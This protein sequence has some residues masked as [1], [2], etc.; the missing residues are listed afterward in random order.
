MTE[1]ERACE[2]MLL[3]RAYLYTLLHKAF[4]GEPTSELLALLGGREAAEVLDLFAEDSEV[5]AKC[6]AFLAERVAAAD[7][8]LVGRCADEYVAVMYGFP[9]ATAL[10]SESFY[11]S[12]DHAQL[13]EV[14]LAVRDCYRAQ[15]LLPV[16]YP[17]T[18]DD[19]IALEMDFMARLSQES[20]AVLATR[21]WP[22]L[23]LLLQ[24]QAA[25][26]DDH[27]NAWL[28]LFAADMRTVESACLYPQLAQLAEAFAEL[29]RQ[30]LNNIAAWLVDEAE[31][32]AN[33]NDAALAIVDAAGP[34]REA[35]DR[36][37]AV[38]LPH[39]EDNELAPMAL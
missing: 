6:R 9:K 13:S 20:A 28:P 27:V 14:T 15:G 30:C 16:R 19:H 38:R 11:C 4:G 37:R 35:L 10:P 25:F 26:L 31:Q 17:R 22:S 36:L 33:E 8:E 1:D 3:A 5:V 21:D 7:D 29:D 24:A 23:V 39:L 34:L 18:P 32:D 2:T 12:S